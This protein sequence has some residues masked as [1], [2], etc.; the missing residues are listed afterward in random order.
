MLSALL[1]SDPLTKS[2]PVGIVSVFTKETAVKQEL[3]EV[4]RDKGKLFYFNRLMDEY[5]PVTKSDVLSEAA[6][7]EEYARR[8][9]AVVA[10][11]SLST[12]GV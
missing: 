10:G 6:R 5:M 2:T 1:Y 11:E 4:L 8:L 9:R 7:A 12:A 3:I